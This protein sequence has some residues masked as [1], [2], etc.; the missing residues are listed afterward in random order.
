MQKLTRRIEDIIEKDLNKKMVFLAGPR[1]SGKTTIA[2]SLIN[3][4]GGVY[5]NWD[6]IK[7]RDLIK[8]NDLDFKT[9]F[10]V[11]DEL[12]K[13]RA[14]RNWL[15]GNYDLHKNDHRIFVTGSA[16]LDV[17]SRGGDSLQG[18]Y[19][20]HR[21]HPLTLSEVLGLSFDEDLD[22]IPKLSQTSS[23]T[24]YQKALKDLIAYSGFPEPFLDSSEKAYKRWKLSYISRLVREEIRDLE[25]VFE[26]DKIETLY[27][28]LPFTVG[29]V[30]S[31]NSLREDLEVNHRSV[32]HWI[33][34]LE[35]N[36]ACFRLSPYG[37]PKI[38]AVKKEQK[39][40]MWDW[41]LTEKT[42]SR[43]ENLI[44]MHLL[45]LVD[46]A[47]DVHGIK[48]E[49]RYFRDLK[50]REV[51]FIL[52]KEKKPWMA[53][54]VKESEQS[55][56]PN[57]KYLLERTKIPFAFQLHLEGRTYKK[58]ENINSSEIF[59]MPASEFL[60]NLP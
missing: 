33:K 40:Y 24:N 49:L 54:E 3:K 44:A 9:K 53:I 17:Y 55:L 5:Y 46:Y 19:F 28:H 23:Q 26:L 60:V 11:F 41:S 45:R 14:W 50:R 31:I 29:S 13:Y 27:E 39:L 56:D 12:H 7:H 10:W 4:N 16:K 18:R 38:K 25:K 34:I 48:L 21:L 36:Y 32:S 37:P 47:Q 59:I 1:Q 42:S 22:K 20:F 51:D 35:K 6:L 8:K 2:E 30:L 52:I 57:L 43:F 58:L 15:K